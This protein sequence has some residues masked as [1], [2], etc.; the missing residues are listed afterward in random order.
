MIPAANTT[1]VKPRLGDQDKI[2]HEGQLNKLEGVVSND[3]LFDVYLGECIAPYVALDPLK[4]ALPVYRPSMTMPL[5]HDDCEDDKHSA[6]RL[7]VKALH[8]SMRHRW[9]IA[10]KMFRDAHEKQVIKDLYGRL[11]YQNILTSQLEYLRAAS[12]GD[13]TTRVAYTQ[14]GQPTAAIIRDRLAI[15]DRTLYQ[16]VC[17]SEEEAHY[18]IAVLNSDQLATEVKPFCPT[19]WAKKIRHFEK[20][21]WKLP[22]PCYNAD[23]PLHVSLSKL[24]K[25]AERECQAMVVQ[26]EIMPKAPGEAQSRAARRLLRHEWQP[27]SQTA[28]AIEAAVAKLLSDPKQAKLAKQ[29]MEKVQS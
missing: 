25:A 1:N 12:T 29:Q 24:G 20:H 5:N 13:G 23:D 7:E 26:R 11:N 6:C 28:Q 2:T 3:H 8:Q 4:A 17:Q 21:G 27:N 9:N 22:I 16:T 10:D 18:L 19:N 14:S 15:V